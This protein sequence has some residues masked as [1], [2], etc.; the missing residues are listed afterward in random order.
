MRRLP[1]IT[2]TGKQ[3]FVSPSQKP[4]LLGLHPDRPNCVTICEAV[5]YSVFE[6][7]GARFA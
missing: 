3:L 4:K 1:G 7:S 5:L 2:K 6:R